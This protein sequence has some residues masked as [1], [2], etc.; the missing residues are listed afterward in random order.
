MEDF[1][2][3]SA[4]GRLWRIAGRSWSHVIGYSDGAWFREK[5][6]ASTSVSA[7]SYFVL[8]VAFSFLFLFSP[9]LCLHR[10]FFYLSFCFFL[11]SV[12]FSLRTAVPF[13]RLLIR[14][15]Y[16]DLLQNFKAFRIDIYPLA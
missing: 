7:L 8:G 13:F 3:W 1:L 6:S 10:V 2:L 12:V 9:V 15:Y 5:S 14:L 16:Y 11:F 4:F